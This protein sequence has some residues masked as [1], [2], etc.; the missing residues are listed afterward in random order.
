MTAVT[1]DLTGRT[2]VVTGANSGIGRVAAE[3]FARRG[4]EVALVCRSQ[5]RGRLALE[6][7]R[8]HSGNPRVRLFIADFSS[9]ASVAA[10][11]GELLAAYPVI[12][13]LCNNAGGANGGR[14]VT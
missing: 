1:D 12:D 11:A 5:E 4:A 9:L 7:I 8:Q 3:D 2:F 10:V 13:V 14:Q 6:A